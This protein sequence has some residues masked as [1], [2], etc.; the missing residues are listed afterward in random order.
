MARSA[1]AVIA[2]GADG[3]L[4]SRARWAEPT[5]CVGRS[6]TC[7]PRA[8][9]SRTSG[10][11]KL[12]ASEKIA[13]DQAKPL[14]TQ[15]VSMSS[16]ARSKLENSSLGGSAAAVGCA[17]CGAAAGR[18]TV[19]EATPTGGVARGGAGGGGWGGSRRLTRL[20][21]GPTAKRAGMPHFHPAV[22]GPSWAGSRQQRVGRGGERGAGTGGS[23]EPGRRGRIRAV[24]AKRGQAILMSRSRAAGARLERNLLPCARVGVGSVNPCTA[25]P[26]GVLRRE[27]LFGRRPFLPALINGFSVRL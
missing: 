12:V 14:S 2:R 18:A 23:S 20:E 15:L 5:I 6:R 24:G 22:E 13:R 7:P 27:R 3:S 17:S 11:A 10:G 25:R 26:S 21:S 4:R 8:A 19:S 1:S 9:T 16:M